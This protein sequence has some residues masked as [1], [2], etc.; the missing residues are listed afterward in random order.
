MLTFSL[1]SKFFLNSFIGAIM[2]ACEGKTPAPDSFDNQHNKDN[3]E[4]KF[5]SGIPDSI[6]VPN[7]SCS[8]VRTVDGQ[9]TPH[10]A[11]QIRTELQIM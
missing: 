9:S 7:A 6:L 11:L 10:S 1:F 3:N 5:V 2:R 4:D 8:T